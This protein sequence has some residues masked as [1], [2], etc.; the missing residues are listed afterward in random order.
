MH[1]AIL[2]EARRQTSKVSF[3]YCLLVIPLLAET[4]GFPGVDRVLVVDATLELQLSRL[5]ARDR[6]SAEQAQAI[7]SAQ[8]SRE[9]R[10]AMADDMIDNSKDQA[11]LKPQVETLHLQYLKLGM[12]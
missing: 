8:T 7:L 12:K 5:T 4:G 11:Y 2:E 10:L 3:P 6:V 1:P 9:Q